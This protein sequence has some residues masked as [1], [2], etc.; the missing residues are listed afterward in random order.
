MSDPDLLRALDRLRGCVGELPRA[1]QAFAAL[2]PEQRRAAHAV[3]MKIQDR[4]VEVLA[5]L[6]VDMA[7]DGADLVDGQ[8]VP[9]HYGGSG[10]SR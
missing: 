6:V 4:L 10:S 2:D 7:A 9:L 1:E 8:G 5:R 3:G